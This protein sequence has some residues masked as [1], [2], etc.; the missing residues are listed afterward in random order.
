VRCSLGHE[1]F[2]TDRQGARGRSGRICHGPEAVVETQVGAREV[3]DT[4]TEVVHPL[5]APL[6]ERFGFYQLTIDLVAAKV[7]EL[8]SSRF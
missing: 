4:L 5:L 8:Q 7:A 6:Y 2:R 1:Q 3:N